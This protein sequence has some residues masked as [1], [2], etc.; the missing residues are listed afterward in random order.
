M[1]YQSLREFTARLEKAGRLVRVDAPTQ[2]DLARKVKIKID[3]SDWF[4]VPKAVPATG[5]TAVF[6]GG[7]SSS[8][9]LRDGKYVNTDSY[10]ASGE[11]FASRLRA[12]L[13]DHAAQFREGIEGPVR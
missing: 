10:A 11:Q 12:A 3:G 8:W 7:S 6:S 9:Q 13:Q 2:A 5:L 1:P 4:E